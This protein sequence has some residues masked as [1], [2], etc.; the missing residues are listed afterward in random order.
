MS[1]RIE[2]FTH[3][4]A[5]ESP[6]P[7]G[8]SVSAA[9]GALG[10]ALGTM[11]ANLSS[12][13]RGWDDRWREFSDVAEKGK[14][15]HDELLRLVDEDTEAFNGIMAA[16]RADASVRDA[17]IL[18]ATRVA[19]EV[20]LRVMR[21]ALDALDV[22]EAMAERGMEASLSDAAVGAL[23]IRTAVLGA[24]LNVRINAKDLSDAAARDEYLARASALE[25][26]VRRREAALV[27][28]VAKRLG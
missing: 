20:P 22:C 5:S 28:A 21:T 13:R 23:C 15:C 6:A 26:E 27:D 12:H 11:V 14:A 19:I 24:G 7:G 18:E 16:W 17:A 3:E 8:G 25:E 1:E 2:G 9:V 10:A 4:T